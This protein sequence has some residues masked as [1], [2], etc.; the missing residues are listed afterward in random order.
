MPF[1]PDDDTV[2]RFLFCVE[3]A[4]TDPDTELRIVDESRSGGSHGRLHTP[5]IDLEGLRSMRAAATAV[6]VPTEVRRFVVDTTAAIRAAENVVIGP[7]TIAALAVVQ[8][9]AALAAAN[10]R[11]SASIDDVR[12]VLIPVLGHRTLLREAVDGSSRDLI[13]RISRRS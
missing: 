7:S 13:E 6:D 4:P 5:V 1:P 10:G 11:N 3:L 8:A 2:E 12:S 9:A